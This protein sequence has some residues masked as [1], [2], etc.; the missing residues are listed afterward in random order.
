M[1]KGKDLDALSSKVVIIML[2]NL[3]D[4]RRMHTFLFGFLYFIVQI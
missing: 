1:K 3:G 2:C 4:I